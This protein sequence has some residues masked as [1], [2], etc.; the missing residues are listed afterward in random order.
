MRRTLLNLII[1]SVLCVPQLVAQAESGHVW[2]VIHYKVFSGHEAEYTATMAEHSR[3]M[4]N[5]LVENGTIV[6]Y[7][8][9]QQNAG[10]GGTSHMLLFEFP[11]FAAMDSFVPAV[12]AA[13]QEVGGET[14][15]EYVAH[16]TPHREVLRTEYWTASVP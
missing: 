5:R 15:E 9:I 8:D 7:L 14:Y 11:N 12:V 2:M 6:S 1:V 13:V 16:F 4:L 3:P 10:D